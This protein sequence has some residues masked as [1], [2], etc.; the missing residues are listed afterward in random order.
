[1]N[2][3][4]LLYEQPNISYFYFECKVC[5]ERWFSTF[6]QCPRCKNVNKYKILSEEEANNY[7]MEQMM[8]NI[9]YVFLVG[10]DH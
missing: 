9:H 5:G 10:E 4:M 7:F 2:M 1:M 6:C 3:E 8:E